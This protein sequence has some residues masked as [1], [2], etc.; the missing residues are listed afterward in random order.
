MYHVLSITSTDRTFTHGRIGP[1][2]M[3]DQTVSTEGCATAPAKEMIY[4]TVCDT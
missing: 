4:I 2:H 3:I 1:S